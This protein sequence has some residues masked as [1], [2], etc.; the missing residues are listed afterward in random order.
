[1]S[2]GNKKSRIVS[3]T[4]LNPKQIENWRKMRWGK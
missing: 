1:M 3:W 4:F 2:Q